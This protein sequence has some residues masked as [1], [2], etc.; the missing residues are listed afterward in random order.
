MNNT[1]SQRFDVLDDLLYVAKLAHQHFSQ[2]ELSIDADRI[3]RMDPMLRFHDAYSIRATA[4]SQLVFG[5]RFEQPVITAFDQALE[6]ND[7]NL[8]V[9][10]FFAELVNAAQVMADKREDECRSKRQAR[11]LMV[12]SAANIDRGDAEPIQFSLS[13]SGE[14]VQWGPSEATSPL[15]RNI[16]AGPSGGS[17]MR[18]IAEWAKSPLRKVKIELANEGRIVHVSGLPEHIEGCDLRLLVGELLLS[19]NPVMHENI[20]VFDMSAAIRA[21]DLTG[22]ESL[23]VELFDP[24]S[25][26]ALEV[27]LQR[28]TD[29]A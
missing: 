10:C 26:N 20:A 19:P 16:A 4:I 21:A 8:C 27:E 28:I 3:L 2:V 18:C 7:P 13:R 12:P 1:S 23:S 24:N 17:T 29:K 15:I 25:A 14:T 9:C 5:D 22:A 11:P 6:I